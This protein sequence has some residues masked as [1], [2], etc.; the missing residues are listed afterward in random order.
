MAATVGSWALRGCSLGLVVALA[1]GPMAALGGD[2]KWSPRLTLIERY[3]DNVGLRPKG[4]ERS[5]WIT[6]I[7]PG[8]AVQRAGRKLKVDVDYSL[9]GYIFADDSDRSRA[10]SNLNGQLQAE[11]LSD[12]FYLDASARASQQLVDYVGGYSLG[13]GV[14]LQ[15]TRQTYA[16]SLSPYLKHRFGSAATVELRVS[17]D[18]YYS[19]G[20][21][22]SDSS[23]HRYH[24]GAESGTN[25][26]PLSWKLDY[27]RRETD[28]QSRTDTDSEQASAHARL[29][30][31][32]EF[33]LIGQ[34]GVEK[35]NFPGASNRI[36]DFS[37]Y[38][39]GVYY[40]PG[41]R[42]FGE[43][44]YN[45]SEEGNFVSGSL[46][47]QPTLRTE[48]NAS[49]TQRNFGRSHTLSANHRTRKT[50]W[51]LVYSESLSSYD[52]L[53][54]EKQFDAWLCGSVYVY[55]IPVDTAVPP[56]CT[57]LNNTALAER[58]GAGAFKPVTLDKIYVSKGLTGYV[59]YRLRR[60]EIQLSLFDTRRLY[61][62]ATVL[63]RE[64][65]HTG[66]QLA[67]NLRPGERTALSV[68]GGLSHLQVDD[69]NTAT[70]HREDDFWNI[71][72]TLTRRF[73][74]NVS[75]SLE[76]R[77]QRRN[78]KQSNQDYAENAVAARVNMRF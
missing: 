45:L 78:A 50:S 40:S 30:L 17:H 74:P 1:M 5:D 23:T 21:G 49:S 7:N 29:R 62:E 15:N 8:I 60:A 13:D 71:G 75:G 44:I 26:L 58:F 4:L 12:W 11:L 69:P 64:D 61:Q 65:R 56:G 14:G 33:G 53:D 72:L 68:N 59:S 63:G 57:K 3:T 24:F 25:F 34:A 6:E 77:H 43:L 70:E 52:Q 20:S 35:G 28:Y 54:Y 41:R 27:D 39:L 73:Q 38:G 19:N 10:R 2:W 55:P 16:Y 76:L 31:Q 51:G 66:L 46:T 36:R 67:V 47:L 22:L 32:R 48:I 42:F 37:Y 9:H 18:Q